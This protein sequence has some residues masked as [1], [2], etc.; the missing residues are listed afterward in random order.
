ME[1][2]FG[3]ESYAMRHAL[4][5]LPAGRRYAIFSLTVA[6]DNLLEEAGTVLHDQS[7]GTDEVIKG[8]ERVR[9]RNILPIPNRQG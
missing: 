9:K 2:A 7:E 5:L 6:F 1:M 3:F 4:C 8:K